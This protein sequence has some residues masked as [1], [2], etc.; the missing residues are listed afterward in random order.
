MEHI[1][2]QE[3][4]SAVQGEFLSGNPHADV[5]A[6]VTDGRTLR[7]GD[8]F[9]ALAGKNFDGHDF[10]RQALENGAD[11]IIVSR[12]NLDLGNPFPNFPAIVRVKDTLK[13]LGDIAAYNRRK[14]TIP[15]VGVTGSNGKTTTKDMLAAILNGKGRTL[16]SEGNYNNQ[17]GL[18]QTLLH[19]DTSHRFAVVEMGSSFPGEIQRLAEITA[20]TM[21]IVTN[22]GSAHLENFKSQEGV[23]EEKTALFRSLPDDGCA[24]VNADDPF[25]RRVMLSLGKENVTYGIEKVAQV[26]AKNI[27]LWPDYPSFDLCIGPD[28]VNVTLPVYGRFNVYNAL[29][30]AASA[31]KLGVGLDAIRTGLQGFIPSKMRMEVR[32]LISGTVFIND[33]Y[34]ANP[35]SVMESVESL[36]QTFP[37]REKVVVLGDMLELGLQAEAEHYKLGEFLASQPLS[38]IFLYGPLMEKAMLV[39]NNTSV[40]HFLEQDKLKAALKHAMPEGGVVLFKASRGMAI[41]KVAD[42]L[43]SEQ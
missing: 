4:I 15:V 8:Y 42:E 6:I 22:I 13:A 21:G 39:L 23:F 2:L 25:L 28:S 30:A 34:N 37:D 29:A 43:F 5:A 19:L 41:E 7:K 38:G 3:L 40:K 24:I 10:L 14:F 16:C 32:R 36:V 1:R 18:P 26:T 20:P 12:E 11:G 27:K 9:L 31:W 33:A 35:V 17:I